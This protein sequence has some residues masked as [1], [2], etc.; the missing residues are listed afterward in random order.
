MSSDAPDDQPPA[1][2]GVRMTTT[3]VVAYLRRAGD[4]VLSLAGAPP[5]SVPMSFGVTD[6]PRLVF[7]CLF[8]PDS[9]KGTRLSETDSASL[10]CYDRASP[11]DWASV[12]V[13]GEM[14]AVEH[15]AE[16]QAAF[17]EHADTVSMNVFE[18][19]AAELS[20]QWYELTPDSMS[21]RAGGHW[22]P[23]TTDDNG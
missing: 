8:G 12:V 17:A 22:T 16:R 11:D 15:D 4:G 18:E 13:T 21:G 1:D 20:V 19:A 6:G 9:E 23:P 2:A 7:Q 14:A 3:Q 5:L 10:V